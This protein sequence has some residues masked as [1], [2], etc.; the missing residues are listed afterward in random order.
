MS[1]EAMKSA[2]VLRDV[3]ST[4][5]DWARG[6]KFGSVTITVQDGQ[7][8]TMQKTETIKRLPAQPAAL[9]T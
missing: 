6:R 9:K 7:I 2:D 8:V 5:V 1:G 3:S 4:L